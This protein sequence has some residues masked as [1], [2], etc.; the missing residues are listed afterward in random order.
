LAASRSRHEARAFIQGGAERAGKL[1]DLEFML[2]DRAFAA[3]VKTAKEW[4]A[5]KVEA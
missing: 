3:I 5:V 4:P 1:R 2:I